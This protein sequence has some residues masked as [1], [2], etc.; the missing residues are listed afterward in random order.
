MKQDKLAHLRPTTLPEMLDRIFFLLKKNAVFFLAASGLSILAEVFLISFSADSW[1]EA[2]QPFYYVIYFPLEVL[3]IWA[4]GMGLLFALQY[5]LFPDRPPAFK[6]AAKSVFYCVPSVFFVLL[7]IGFAMVMF[8]GILQPFEEVAADPWG[9]GSLALGFFLLGL[10]LA[11]R[12]SLAPLL[13]IMEGAGIFAAIARSRDLMRAGFGGGTGQ[14]IT[15]R[16]I[17]V[18]GLSAGVALV[19]AILV[20]AGLY[21][22]GRINGDLVFGNPELKRAALQAYVVGLFIAQPIYWA[23]IALIY[24]EIRVRKDGLD[25][26]LRLAENN[27]ST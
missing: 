17:S 27:I 24:T 5:S 13:I 10:L 12:W 1:A 8:L 3:R 19:T 21:F 11:M 20:M 25:F 14:S 16:W 9:R 18:A 2:N 15:A 26:Q 4:V 23:G 6:A 22:S 7:A